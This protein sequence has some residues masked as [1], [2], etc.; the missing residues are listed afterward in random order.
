MH[1]HFDSE[2]QSKVGFYDSKLMK[3]LLVF[4]APHKGKLMIALGLMLLQSV[5]MVVPP[6]MQKIAIDRYI[7][8]PDA[9]GNIMGL[10]VIALLYFGIS[11]FNWFISYGQS[12]VLVW[13]GQYIIYDISIK[14]WLI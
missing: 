8:P 12:Y 7:L 9:P 5:F 6:Y 10:T 14:L 1:M 3:R 2:E 13:M 4:L 11:I